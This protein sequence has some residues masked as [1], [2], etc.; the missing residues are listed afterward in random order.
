MV[1]ASAEK[2]DLDHS[3]AK[4]TRLQSLSSLAFKSNMEANSEQAPYWICSPGPCW[5]VMETGI[6]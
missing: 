4:L 1:S 6:T 3:A 2:L 5:I